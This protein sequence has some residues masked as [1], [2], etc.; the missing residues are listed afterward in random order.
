MRS[1]GTVPAR[2]QPGRLIDANSNLGHDYENAKLTDDQ[3]YELIEYLK[4]L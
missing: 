4:Q 1:R 3:R 2:P